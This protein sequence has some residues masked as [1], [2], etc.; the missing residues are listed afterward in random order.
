MPAKIIK[1]IKWASILLAVV[2]IGFFAIRVYAAQRGPPLSRWHTYVPHD[3]KAKELDAT[4]WDHYL[5]REAKIFDDVRTEVTDKLTPDERV[6]MNRYF[7]GSP[8]YPAHFTQ[9]F[10]RSYVLE[11]SGTPVGAVVLLHGLTDSPYSQRHIAK[12]YRDHGF[13]SIVK[14]GRAHV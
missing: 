1:G 11:P 2:A 5:A 9:D 6:P 10:N 14:I 12:F 13:V 7:D 8:I 3:L 4:D